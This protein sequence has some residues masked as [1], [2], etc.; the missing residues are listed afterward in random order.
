MEGGGEGEGGGRIVLTRLNIICLKNSSLH[1]F[2]LFF[3]CALNFEFQIAL[4]KIFYFC[5]NL[6]PFLKKLFEIFLKLKL[7]ITSRL[8]KKS[9]FLTSFLGICIVVATCGSMMMMKT[10]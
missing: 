4:H 6:L 3:T 5:E 8:N 7:P 10:K 9:G 1:Y 2:K